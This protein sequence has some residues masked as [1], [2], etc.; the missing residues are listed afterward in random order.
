MCDNSPNFFKKRV[1]VSSFFPQQALDWQS[2]QPDLAITEFPPETVDFWS[3]QPNAKQALSVFLRHPSRFLLMLKADDQAEYASLLESFTKLHHH[4][5]QSVFG[6]NYVVEQGDAFS[7]PRVYT[8]VAHSLD[9]NFATPGEVV[10][11]LYCDQFQLFG[12]LRVHP[13]SHDIQLNPGLVH[14]ANGGVLILSAAMLLSQFDLWLRLKHILQTQTFD[15][16][17]A[18][19]FKHL[20][21]D[22]P[23]YKLNLK[24]IVLGSRT[25]LATLGELEESLYSFAD[26]AEIESYISV[27]EVESQK[28]W[29]GYVK[30]IAQTLNVEMN[31]S[32]LNKLYKLLVRESEDRFLINISPLK[33][34]EILQD[35]VT[36]TGNSILSADDFEAVFQRKS[37]Q[38]GFLKEQTYADILNEQVYVETQGEIVG[39]INGLSVIEY[40]GTPVS[41]GEP[42]RISCI[43]QFGEG[44]VID[45]ER[46]N[47]LAGNIHSK[48]M[49]IAQAC[50]SN[51]LDLPSQLPFSAS[52]VFEQSYG[53]IDGDSA[54]LAIF[55]VLVSALSDLPLPQNIAITGSIDQFGLVHSVGGVNDKIEGFFTI[56]QRRGLTGK[57]GVIIPM[58]TIQ[59]L[60][61]S[62]EVKSAVKNNEFFIYPAEDI[63]QACE[64]LFERDLLDENKEYSEKTMPISRLIQRRIENRLDSE[65]KGFWDF[66]KS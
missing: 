53:E 65:K 44:E 26:Y 25:E 15:W 3:L 29:A 24:V 12:S 54:S 45:V 41:F 43:V 16:Y 19:P 18:H 8:E 30:K 28:M 34:K 36:L 64:Y 55:C 35:V 9:D 20:P 39:Q 17:S 22:V 62:D 61:L 57:Q 13:S 59:Q 63:Y 52:L 23:S 38:H 60:S 31:F 6:V 51:I 48:G 4:R 58:T 47:E 27:A 56:C 46:K 42:S 37:I 21:C 2:L 49:M 14:R 5:E 66:F 33:L 10:N 32:A 1:T 40:P 11:A 50:L 7:F